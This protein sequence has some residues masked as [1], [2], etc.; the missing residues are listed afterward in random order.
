MWSTSWGHA[1]NNVALAEIGD[2]LLSNVVQK[3]IIV[4]AQVSLEICVSLCLASSDIIEWSHLSSVLGEVSF[5]L[6]LG[7]IS[8]DVLSIQSIALQSLEFN[9]DVILLSHCS[10]NLIRLHVS[11]LNG[12][13]EFIGQINTWYL[14]ELNV[15]IALI[16]QS[17]CEAV[18]HLIIDGISWCEEMVSIV[19][20]GSII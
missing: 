7:L 16:K 11:L 1:C 5:S 14:E 13:F 19:S 12:L 17:L 15:S 10:I 8:H 18:S 20:C 9:L 6:S 3:L 2:H 4:H